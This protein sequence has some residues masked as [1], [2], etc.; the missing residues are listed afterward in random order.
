LVE[1]DLAKVEVAGS[2]PVSRSTFPSS[3]RA[4]LV[5]GTGGNLRSGQ[6]AAMDGCIP[7]ATARARPKAENEWVRYGSATIVDQL[8][9]LELAEPGAAAAAIYDQP[10]TLRLLH[11]D[12]TS[13]E[14]HYLVRYPAGV[15]GR[16]H[17]H[18]AAHTIIVLD[19]RLE[20][21]GRVIGP[22]AYVH[23]PPGEPMQHQATV[24]EPCL[25]VL[26]FHGAFDVEALSE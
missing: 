17:R 9:T 20:A 12:P 3:S 7:Q 11:Q 6:A 26:L 16:P 10:I 5:A 21:N 1:R 18:T 23:F 24:D 14:E 8:R 4:T 15:R 25:F 22:C 19:G 2:K 13:G